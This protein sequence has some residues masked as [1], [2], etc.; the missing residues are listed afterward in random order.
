[1]TNLSSTFSKLLKRRFG[2]GPE[3]CHV[4]L[5]GNRFYVYMRNFIT[6]AEEVMM[7]NDQMELALHFRT[8][9]INSV[10]EEFIPEL[11]DVLGISFDYFYHDWNYDKNTGIL[12]FDHDQNN[13]EKVVIRYQSELFHLIENVG[14]HYHKKPSSIKIVKFT[15]NICAIESKEVILPLERLVYK[16][17]N[18]DLL[19]HHACEIKDGYWKNKE[20]FENL[21]NRLIEDIFIMWDYKNNKHYLVFIFSKFYN[22]N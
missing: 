4:I 10:I 14:S 2:K 9:V 16:K 8:A 19:Y 22:L 12:L 1:M 15:Q 13:E 11:E 20:K 17:G 7:N 18:V 6:P 21:F 3:T 5:K